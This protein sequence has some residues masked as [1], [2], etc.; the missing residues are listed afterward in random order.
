MIKPIAS[1]E[2]KSKSDRYGFRDG[3][4]FERR[5]PKGGPK[6]PDT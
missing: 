2:V 1:M 6:S 3:L 5:M 4:A